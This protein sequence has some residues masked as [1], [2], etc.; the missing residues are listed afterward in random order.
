MAP[1]AASRRSK[2]GGEPS[3]LYLQVKENGIV[4]WKS[5]K[6]SSFMHRILIQQIFEKCNKLIRIVFL[7]SLIYC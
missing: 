2:I 6:E 7:L 4:F 5:N 1:F 3:A